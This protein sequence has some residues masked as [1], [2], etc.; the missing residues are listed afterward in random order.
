MSQQNKILAKILLGA[1]D[2]NIP[3]AQ[4]CHLLRNLG[5]EER[6]RG[7]H[8]IFTKEGVEEILN[9]QPK[10]SQAKAYQVKQIRTVII[11]Y[12]L[13]DRNDTSL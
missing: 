11:K 1:S 10:G 7:N 2:A 6:I 13:G 9:L 12:N 8:H 4:L 3:F 5:F